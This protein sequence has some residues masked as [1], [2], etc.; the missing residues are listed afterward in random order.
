[1]EPLPKS[2]GQR[3]KCF[4]SLDL[5]LIFFLVGCQQFFS[6]IWSHRMSSLAALFLFY[7]GRLSSRPVLYFQQHI[8]SVPPRW[9]LLAALTLLPEWPKVTQVYNL[10]LEL[11]CFICGDSFLRTSQNLCLTRQAAVFWRILV[12]KSVWEVKIKTLYSLFIRGFLPAEE[13]HWCF[14]HLVFYIF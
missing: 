11:Q 5:C 13:P 1:M 6:W 10:Q 3:P 7:V 14:S 8:L 12:L 4:N 9:L 2:G